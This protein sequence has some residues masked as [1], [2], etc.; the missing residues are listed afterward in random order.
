M[1]VREGGGGGVPD[2]V[3]IASIVLVLILAAWTELQVWGKV[4]IGNEK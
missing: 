4:W 1:V 2:I 3:E